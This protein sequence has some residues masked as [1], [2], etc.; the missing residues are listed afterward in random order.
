MGAEDLLL[1]IVAWAVVVP[2][3]LW[4][5]RLHR[6]RWLRRLLRTMEESRERGYDHDKT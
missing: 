5:D 2:G 6:G 3:L 1:L 4:L